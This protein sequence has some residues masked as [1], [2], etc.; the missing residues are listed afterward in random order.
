MPTRHIVTNFPL[1]TPTDLT[2]ERRALAEARNPQIKIPFVAAREHT[3]M[4][5]KSLKIAAREH[6]S[7]KLVILQLVS[8]RSDERPI[9]GFSGD[10][11]ARSRGRHLIIK[12]GLA[13]A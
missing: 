3:D 7:A 8:I 12:W 1:N 10:A 9:L 6:N 5:Q 13:P 2:G 4:I 11:V